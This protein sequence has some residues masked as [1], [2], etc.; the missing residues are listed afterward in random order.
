MKYVIIGVVTAL[1]SFIILTMTPVSRFVVM[2]TKPSNRVLSQVT[3]SLSNRYSNSYVNNV[4]ADNILLTLAY[5]SGKVK[6][7]QNIPWKTV[8]ST[9][10]KTL[11]LKPGQTFAFH[12][13]VL[14]KYKGK[15]A[16]TTNAHFNSDE[17]FKSDGWLVGDGVCHLASFMYVAALNAGLLLEAPT[18][19][20]FAT[21]P[22]VPKQAGVSIF[23]S[24]NNPSSSTLQNLYITNN[25]S[26]TI[27]FVF[28]Q[29]RN[30]LKIKV[31]ELN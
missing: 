26:K 16:L 31:E 12:D 25:Y 13:E 1:I 18:R 7:G 22:D 24:P 30:D 27:A 19:H 23:Y 6:E 2:P 8:K 9:D 3:Y 20:D 5:M 21:I 14:E 11:V 29:S 10:V 15:V 17:G 4:F 28:A